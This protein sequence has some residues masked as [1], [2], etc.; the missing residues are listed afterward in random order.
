MPTDPSSHRP[1]TWSL[2]AVTGDGDQGTL[3]LWGVRSPPFGARLLREQRWAAQ[4][5]VPARE[6]DLPPQ[7]SAEAG[8]TLA[9]KCSL[10]SVISAAPITSHH[11]VRCQTTSCH[12]VSVR[13]ASC[14]FFPSQASGVCVCPQTGTPALPLP[15]GCSPHPE[16]KRGKSR[17]CGSLGDGGCRLERD[18]HR[19]SARRTGHT[20]GGEQ[21]SAVPAEASQALP[22]PV[23][24]AAGGMQ[25][26]PAALRGRGCC[27]G[28]GRQGG[29]PACAKAAGGARQ[30]RRFKCFH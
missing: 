19:A 26:P 11:L 18:P 22:C 15:A 1:G 29:N 13:A 6:R 5:R 8:V 14:P 10:E 30:G 16:R 27:T 2:E 4:P 9:H 24:T 7:P 20:E 28:R 17:W 23:P 25:C 21:R 12:A 3:S